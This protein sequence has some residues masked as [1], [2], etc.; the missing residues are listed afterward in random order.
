MRNCELNL[1]L[2]RSTFFW[3]RAARGNSSTIAKR[4]FFTNIGF[5]H[6]HNVY[7][8]E[9]LRI[10][11]PARVSRDKSVPRGTLIHILSSILTVNLIGENGY[12][13]IRKQ[14]AMI[15]RIAPILTLMLLWFTGSSQNVVN[16]AVATFM[17][18]L[19]KGEIFPGPKQN[20]TTELYI[21]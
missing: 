21:K 19:E 11:R 17:T 16:E 4:C 2:S 18:C 12:L 1:N 6:L 9:I 13:R 7:I 14:L 5:G 20:R 8:I 15:K 3:L 10:S